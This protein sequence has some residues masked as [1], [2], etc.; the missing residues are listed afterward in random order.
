MDHQAPE[1]LGDRRPTLGKGKG[2]QEGGRGAVGGE[3]KGGI[4]KGY[5]LGV[6]KPLE[7]GP[8]AA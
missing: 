7:M 5:C 6:L 1:G 8:R 3:A 2:S 4:E